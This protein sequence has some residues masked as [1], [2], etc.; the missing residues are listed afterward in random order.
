M[1]ITKYLLFLAL[2]ISFCSGHAKPTDFDQIKDRGTLRV[3]T[4]MGVETWLPRAGSPPMVEQEYLQQFADKHGLELEL[5]T[6]EKFDDMIPALLANKGDVIAANFAVTG[7]RQKEVKFTAPFARTTEF[8]VTG[9]NAKVIPDAKALAGR[10]IAV[11]KGTTYAITARG[12]ARANPGLK[13]RY[14]KGDLA[15]D[16]MM[17][18]IASGE[19]DITILDD[20]YLS[21]LLTYRKDIRKSL[22]ASAPRDIAWAVSPGNKKLLETLNGYLK[23]QGLV[24]TRISKTASK[25]AKTEWDRIKNRG[26]IRFVLR[27]NI[28]SYYIWRGEIIGFHADIARDFAKEHKLRYELINAPDNSAL[29]TYVAEGKGDVALGFLTPTEERKAM[30]IAFSRPYHY[31]SE[32]IA[33]HADDDSIKSIADLKGR[34]IYIR[35]SS[36]YWQTAMKLKQEVPELNVVPVDETITTEEIIEGVSDKTYDLTIADSHLV[37]MEINL[38]EQVQIVMEVTKPQGQSWAVKEG[39]N[40]LLDKVNRYI[41]KKYKGLFYNV[42]YNKY[43]KNE[44]RMEKHRDTARSMQDGGKLSPYDDLVKKYADKYGYDYRLMVSQMHQESKFNPKAKSYTGARGLF[45]VMPRTAKSIGFNPKKLADP[46]TGIHAGIKYLDWVSERFDHYDIAEDEL[47]WFTLAAYNAGSGHVT[48]AI[49]LAKQKGYDETRWFDNVERAM[50]LLSQK[51]YA[52]KARYGFVRGKEPVNYVRQIKY[53]YDIYK[54]MTAEKATTA[55][56]VDMM[57]PSMSY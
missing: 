22:Q 43:F 10:E 36:A 17:D 34:S 52:D 13:V 51:K 9:K 45:Q 16:E 28:P 48:D 53:R 55:W 15:R 29:I 3:I 33:S 12:L 7:K 39:N 30:G 14:V 11:Q 26:V 31:S 41:R 2:L 35:R 50:L 24:K 18:K 57:M 21:S 27:N 37:E 56:Y 38:G 32:V 49:R 23:E 20:N 42:T 40:V 54:E 46:E 8:L 1:I 4:W 5:V 44:T 6:L 19:Y 47:I 25:K